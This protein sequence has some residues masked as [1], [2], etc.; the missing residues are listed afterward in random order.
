MI[1][2]KFI[3]TSFLVNNDRGTISV[4]PEMHANAAANASVASRVSRIFSAAERKCAMAASVTV[5]SAL[6]KV[7]FFGI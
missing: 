1:I 6:E 4:V 2:S 7:E 3:H 5:S